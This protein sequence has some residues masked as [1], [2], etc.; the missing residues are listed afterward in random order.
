MFAGR[1]IHPFF[2]SWKVEKKS[3]ESADS[4]CSLSDAK[5]E[6]GRTICGPIHVFEDSRVCS[7]FYDLMWQIDLRL[8]V[9]CQFREKHVHFLFLFWVLSVYRGNDLL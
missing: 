3:R 5:K 9:E 1:Q 4:E 7:S 8:G 2:S 6:N